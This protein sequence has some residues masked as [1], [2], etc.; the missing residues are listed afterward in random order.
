MRIIILKFYSERI[1]P[2]FDD[3][4]IRN[5]HVRDKDGSVN[6]RKEPTT[7]SEIVGAA[8]NGDYVCYVPPYKPEPNWVHIEYKG[9]SGYIHS[10]R[11]V[12]E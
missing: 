2:L 3:F 6:I 7:S 11:L 10:S 5:Y 12:R 1:Y 4:E 9:I 8:Q